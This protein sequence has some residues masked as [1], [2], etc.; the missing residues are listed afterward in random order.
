MGC[1]NT[2]PPTHTLAPLQLADCGTCPSTA[3]TIFCSPRSPS[4]PC[5]RTPW[6]AADLE[7][8]TIRATGVH[9]NVSWP[10][11]QTLALP[12]GM[13]VAPAVQGRDALVLNWGPWRS[14]C[15]RNCPTSPR[16]P[17]SSGSL[18]GRSLQT[19]VS[20]T[21]AP[22]YG[23]LPEEHRTG[24]WGRFSI[25]AVLRAASLSVSS[26]NGRFQQ[27][28]STS[29]LGCEQGWVISHAGQRWPPK[30][31]PDSGGVRRWSAS[32][33]IYGLAMGAQ[34]A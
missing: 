11:R 2:R 14:A 34:Q 24:W 23:G 1:A 25:N 8:K 28:P 20:S 3:N 13:S 32:A 4:M 9:R 12:T 5:P 16:L 7:H 30:Q 21:P 17:G 22:P 10:I 31:T 19:C 27:P 6:I 15:G 18:N 26:R 29:A 33:L